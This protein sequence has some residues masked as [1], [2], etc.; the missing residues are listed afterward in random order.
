MNRL[1]ALRECVGSKCSIQTTESGSLLTAVV[2]TA[3]SGALC[4]AGLHVLKTAAFSVDQEGN[5]QNKALGSVA[6]AG[7]GVL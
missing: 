5:V 4:S 7:I 2:Q 3:T 1:I 6:E